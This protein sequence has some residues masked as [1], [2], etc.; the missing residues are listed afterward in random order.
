MNSL[1]A[2]EARSH[3]SELLHQVAYAKERV[4][5][6]R[7]GKKLVAVVPL[8]DIKMLDALENRRDL[9]QAR[10]ALAGVAKEGTLPWESVKK[11]LPKKR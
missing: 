9:A 2:A 6:T 8:R 10:K 4:F 1:S 7:N 11:S 5:L 3:F